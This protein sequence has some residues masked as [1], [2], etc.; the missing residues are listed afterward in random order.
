[1]AAAYPWIRD[2]DNG[3]SQ[4]GK[5]VVTSTSGLGFTTASNNNITGLTNTQLSIVSPGTGTVA[6]NTKVNV[7]QS[8]ILSVGTTTNDSYISFNGKKLYVTVTDPATVVG[9]TVAAGDIW[10]ST[11]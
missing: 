4:T 9:N 2:G 6:I 11:A 8:G 5:L 7:S 1:M 3:F 10:I